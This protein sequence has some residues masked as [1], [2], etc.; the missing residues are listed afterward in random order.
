MIV[1][2]AGSWLDFCVLLFGR[3]SY[4]LLSSPAVCEEDC[5]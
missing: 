3:Q 4:V 1:A 2:A 5:S